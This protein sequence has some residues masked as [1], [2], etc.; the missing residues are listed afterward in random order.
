MAV[1]PHA[2]ARIETP[3]HSG[4][5]DYTEVAPHAG[6][7]IETTETYMPKMVTEV[8]LHAGAQIETAWQVAHENL[9]KSL[10]MRERELKQ[11]AAKRAV[12]PYIVAPHAGAR[13]ETPASRRW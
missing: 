3:A 9:L 4:N 2:G 13:I 6:A 8:A 12:W 10:P 11:R 1:A 5:P 7:R